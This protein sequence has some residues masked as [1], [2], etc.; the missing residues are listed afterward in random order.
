M[1]SKVSR[2]PVSLTSR[3]SSVPRSSSVSRKGYK[4]PLTQNLIAVYAVIV[5]IVL[6]AAFL[7]IGKNHHEVHSWA[8]MHSDINPVFFAFVV[9]TLFILAAYGSYLGHIGHTGGW[10]SFLLSV[11]GLIL[12]LQIL[13]LWLVYRSRSFVLAFWLSV[14]LTVAMTVH[15]LTV[16]KASATGALLQLPL[17]VY[18][19]MQTYTLWG[20]TSELVDVDNLTEQ[21]YG[22]FE[23]ALAPTG[24]VNEAT[25]TYY[26]RPAVAVV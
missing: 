10:V 14:A 5:I 11:I 25:S 15:T 13:V 8:R 22:I 2:S 21:V 7:I 9:S 16:F 18:L 4:N 3:S 1:S 17:W 20:V 23:P 24:F 19:I 6:V 12:L 26:T